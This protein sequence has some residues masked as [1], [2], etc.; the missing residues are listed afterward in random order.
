MSPRLRTPTPSRPSGPRHARPVSEARVAQEPEPM[1]RI[2]D[3]ATGPLGRTVRAN[4][5][6]A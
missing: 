6:V 3:R 2:P 1:T 5:S 4:L